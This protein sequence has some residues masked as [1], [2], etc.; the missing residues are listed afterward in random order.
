[1]PATSTKIDAQSG[2]TFHDVTGQPLY[3]GGEFIK[4]DTSPTLLS[5]R[6]ASA[7]WL[8]LDRMKESIEE[9]RSTLRP[10][11]QNANWSAM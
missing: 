11:L 5:E 8:E 1:M 6:E 9:V 10:L 2:S 7:M 4:P 3:Q